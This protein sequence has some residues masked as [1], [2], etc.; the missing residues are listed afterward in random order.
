V[1]IPLN[2]LGDYSHGVERINIRLSIGNKLA[3]LG[4]IKSY[5]HSIDASTSLIKDKI[6]HTLSLLDRVESEWQDALTSLEQEAGFK[7][8]QTSERVISYVADF[9]QPLN[10]LLMG[11]VF[12]E[13]RDKVK[14]IHSEYREARLFVATH[15]HAGDGNV[16]T[17]IPVHSH[18]TQMLESAEKVVDEIMILAQQLGG[19]ISGEH[20]ILKALV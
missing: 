5:F 15:M 7:A 8:L 12:T 6:N 14:T 3:T 18:N 1:V 13:I 4:A 10:D 17:N 11:D 2:K 19:V 16:H 9:S 20:G